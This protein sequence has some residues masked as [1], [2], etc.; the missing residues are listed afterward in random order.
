V[1]QAVKKLLD[2][3]GYFWWMT[4]ANGYGVSGI[5]DFLAFRGGTL[6]AIETKFGSN[7]P[8][9][10]QKAFLGSITAESGFGFVVNDKNIEWLEAFLADF[11]TAGKLAADK[12]TIPAEDGARMMNAMKE[13]MLY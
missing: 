7:K 11:D 3:H 9:A 12:Q 2:R 10:L 4:P 8:T 1:K 5:S 6:M 13:M